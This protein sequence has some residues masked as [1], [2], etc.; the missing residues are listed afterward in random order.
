MY[1]ALSHSCCQIYFDK[2]HA[3]TMRCRVV[4]AV[5]NVQDN[6][7]VFVFLLYEHIGN[8]LF[9]STY[10]GRYLY[11]FIKRESGYNDK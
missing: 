1:R 8:I 4:V 11:E 5:H 10:Y 3:S 2:R 7:I 9:F 6:S